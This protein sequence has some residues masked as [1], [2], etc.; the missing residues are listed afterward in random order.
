MNLQEMR[1]IRNWL[2]LPQTHEGMS[3]VAFNIISHGSKDGWLRSADSEGEGLHVHDVIGTLTDVETLRGK[4][5]LL[6]LNACR[7]GKIIFL[8][9]SNSK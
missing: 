5:K 1:S 9:K 2:A 6:F 8:L 7:G 3:M 4:P